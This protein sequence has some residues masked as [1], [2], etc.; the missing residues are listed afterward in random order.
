[1]RNTLPAAI[2]A[3]FAALGL[4]A[5]V[6][7]KAP[8]IA[9]V[10]IG[11]ATTGWQDTPGKQ[12]LFVIAEEDADVAADQARRAVESGGDPQALKVH[13][14][15]AGHALDPGAYAEGQGSGYGFLKALAGAKD[16]ILYAAESKDA[17]ENVRASAPV[18]AGQVDQVLEQGQLA[19]ALAL[20]IAQMQSTPDARLLAEEL[21]AITLQI[22]D[23]E[24]LDASGV[25]GDSPGELGMR[26][27]RA[28]LEAMIGR[29]DPPYQPVARKYLFGLVRL[30]SG[31][32]VFKKS[33]SGS[34]R[35]G[36]SDYGY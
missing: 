16:H 32:W 17:S 11:H 25:I 7:T 15:S 23:G 2:V 3:T 20:E 36:Y 28:E 30:P 1:M 9:H 19:S 24:D 29:E 13:V 10:H 6:T 27:L 26:Q 14:A 21:A 31:E 33:K 8:A 12:G 34:G 22:R 18:W 5:C 35:Y 4:Q